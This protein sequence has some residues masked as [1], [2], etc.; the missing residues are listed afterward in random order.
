MRG[1]WG[2]SQVRSV[3][4]VLDVGFKMQTATGARRPKCF[5]SREQAKN[6]LLSLTRILHIFEDMPTQPTTLLLWFP[7]TSM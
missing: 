3:S 1:T 6:C 5:V 2:K 4:F 7:C